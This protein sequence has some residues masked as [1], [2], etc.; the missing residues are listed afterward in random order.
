MLKI[1]FWRIEN[2]IL[3]KIL[4]QGDEIVRGCGEFFEGD[5]VLRS[6]ARPQIYKREIYLQGHSM[7]Y[8]GK[9]VSLELNSA[10]EAKSVLKSYVKTIKAYNTSLGKTESGTDDI[11]TVVAE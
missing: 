8:D 5:V 2:V 4:E 9:C 11:E 3:M 6:H 7:D 10:E 1:K